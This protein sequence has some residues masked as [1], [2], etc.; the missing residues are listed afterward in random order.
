MVNLTV[1][2]SIDMRLDKYFSDQLIDYSRSQIQ[3]MIQ[4][5]KVM[6]DGRKQKSSYRLQGREAIVVA[7]IQSQPYPVLNEPQ[8]IPLSIVY[9][10]DAILVIDKQPDWSS[11]P[12]QV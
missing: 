3:A 1:P 5:G 11:N 12:E 8:D 10:D 7:P 4:D 6:I 2:S 9:E